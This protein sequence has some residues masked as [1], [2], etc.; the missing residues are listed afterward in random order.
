MKDI[1]RYS[2]LR[3]LFSCTIASTALAGPQTVTYYNKS[4]QP[5]AVELEPNGVNSDSKVKVD[6]KAAGFFKVFLLPPRS[7][8][9][10]TVDSG[11]ALRLKLSDKFG[12]WV[13][14]ASTWPGGYGWSNPLDRLKPFKSRTC[15]QVVYSNLARADFNRIKAAAQWDIPENGDLTIAADTLADAG[16]GNVTLKD[17][18]TSP[19][20]P[21]YPSYLFNH[22]KTTYRLVALTRDGAGTGDAT[23]R[24]L[25]TDL[26]L[27][28]LLDVSGPKSGACPLPPGTYRL[29]WFPAAQTPKGAPPFSRSMTLQ[30]G[31][32]SVPM[33]WSSQD[34][35]SAAI[36]PSN[37]QPASFTVA[38]IGK[39]KVMDVD[40][41]PGMGVI[42]VYGDALPT[43]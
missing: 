32:H 41:Q 13:E 39:K 23:G 24:L 15:Y 29:F 22:S 17:G 10:V 43:P 16:P 27:T 7:S 33:Q 18:L 34:G 3:F 6:G 26:N 28:P 35:R 5:F 31:Q 2:M 40:L 21:F 25:V 1:L 30:E 11:A 19:A 9:K 12:N 20:P 38:T 8:T 36:F 37:A 4:S 14:V 42:D